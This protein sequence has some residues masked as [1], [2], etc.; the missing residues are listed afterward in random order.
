[1]LSSVK[2]EV[3]YIVLL[4]AQLAVQA[5]GPELVLVSRIT[6]FVWAVIMGAAISIFQ[7]AGVNVY[8]LTIWNGII[9]A[10]E[11]QACL[12]SIHACYSL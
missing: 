4:I 6:V 5:S 10:G 3:C 11:L 7:S 8:W 1:M 9:C 12:L 2:I